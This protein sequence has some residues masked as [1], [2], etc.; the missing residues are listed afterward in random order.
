MQEMIRRGVLMPWIAISLA[1]GDHELDAT[2]EAAAAAL[3]VYA[4]ALEDGVEHFLEG[5]AVKPVF[6]RYN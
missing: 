6:R 5:P 3:E 2:L 1:H 4:K